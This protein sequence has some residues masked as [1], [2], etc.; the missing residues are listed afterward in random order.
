MAKKTKRAAQPR[1]PTSVRD[2]QRWLERSTRQ[3]IAA[4]YDGV[5]ASAQRVLRA[6]IASPEQRVEA[7]DRLGAA[8]SMLQEYAEAYAAVSA[9]LAIT[10]DS[11][12]LRYN[13]GMAARYTMRLGQSLRDLE[14]AAEL[15][16]DGLLAQRLAED[17]PFARSAVAD[18]LKLRGPGSTLDQLIEQE[19]LF[20]QGAQ[21]MARHDWAEAE[22][23]FRRVIDLGDVLPQPWGNLGL[24][25]MMQRQFDDAEAALRR[26]LEIDPNYA[27]ARQNLA[28]L[29]E[30]RASGELPQIQLSNPLKGRSGKQH[31][32]LLVEGEKQLRDLR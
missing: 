20:Q 29:P 19:E 6:P 13:R 4:D 18:A 26:A 1:N 3:L 32:S 28:G 24:C 8:Y 31:L 14:R 27:I 25:L 22:A 30:I 11:P 17:L 9:A 16:A 12:L 21:A 15:D 7:L 23:L 2:I 10:P 5:I